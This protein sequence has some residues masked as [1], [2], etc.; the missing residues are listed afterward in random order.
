MATDDELCARWQQGDRD[1]G[2]ALFEAH[3]DAMYRFFA[4]KINEPDELVQAT[5]LAC[6]HARERFRKQSSFRTYLFAI[7][8]NTLLHHLRGVHRA[9][10]FDPEQS[11]IADLVTTPATRLARQEDKVRLR[12]ALRRLPVEQQTLLELHYWEDLDAAALAEVFEAPA[13]T[14]R[15]RLHRARQALRELVEGLDE[16]PPEV[17]TSIDS[18]DEGARSQAAPARGT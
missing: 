5:F 6:L 12:A 17:A 1:A 3:F 13:A 18:L 2:Q 4:N 8:R 16:L 9:Q 11:S 7:A 14:M 10:R 15:V